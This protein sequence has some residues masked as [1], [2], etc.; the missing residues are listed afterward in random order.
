MITA[1]NVEAELY[2]VLSENKQVMQMTPPPPTDI[3][4]TAIKLDWT[5][6]R[7]SWSFHGMP[8]DIARGL[9]NGELTIDDEGTVR[10]V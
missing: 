3:V 10:T 9:L 4:D 2:Q 6:E 7:L 5:P 8:I 1:A